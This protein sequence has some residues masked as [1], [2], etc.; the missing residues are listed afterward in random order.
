MDD[1]II[2]HYDKNYLY[3]I[4]AKIETFLHDELRLNL[5]PKTG[6]FPGKHGIDFCGY[7][8]WPTHIKPRRSTVKRA[9]RRLKKM[10]RDYSA[11]PSSLEHAKASLNSFLGYIIHCSGFETT[12]HLLDRIIFNISDT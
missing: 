1:F 10:A 9:K 7:W 12:K 2:I 8:I 5:N 3:K 4:L 6:I 11:D